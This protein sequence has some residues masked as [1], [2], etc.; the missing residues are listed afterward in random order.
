MQCA[1]TQ[2]RKPQRLRRRID[3]PPERAVASSPRSAAL[4]KSTAAPQNRSRRR[5]ECPPQEK[6]PFCLLLGEKK[7]GR[8]AGRSARGLK[9]LERSIPGKSPPEDERARQRRAPTQARTP[10][11]LR[12]SIDDPPERA[13]A[14][15]PRSA[16]LVKS[17]AVHQDRSRRRKE[18]PPQEKTPFCLLLGEQK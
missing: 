6:T 17:T 15:S 8:G 4:V 7:V 18:C 2:A 16:I 9:F 1:P 11:R 13:V 12:R 10:Q 5:K 3:D 14:S